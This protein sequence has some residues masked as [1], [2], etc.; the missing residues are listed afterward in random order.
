MTPLQKHLIQA[1]WKIIA[2]LSS[3]LGTLFYYRLFDLA[4]HTRQLFSTDIKPQ[5]EKFVLMLDRVVQSI[6][7]FENL[8]HRLASLGQQH[9][10]LNI[11]A[12]DYEQVRRALLWTLATALEENWSIELEKAWGLAYDELAG[13]MQASVETRENVTTP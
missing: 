9:Q 4:P 2:P 11:T 10:R 12:E 8:T 3:T 6:H 5:V 13:V 1:S 7:E